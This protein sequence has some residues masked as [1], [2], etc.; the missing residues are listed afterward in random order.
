LGETELGGIIANAGITT[1][2]NLKTKQGFE[3][4]F[5]V[6]VLSHQL[7]LREIADNLRENSRIVILSSGVHEPDHKLAR[8]T[9]IPVPKWLGTRELAYLNAEGER[10]DFEGRRRYSTSK[11]GNV[12]QARGLQG[13]LNRKGKSIDVFAVDP[14]LMV[15]TE[16]ARELP[17]LLKLIFQGV[18]RL[19]TPFIDNMRLSDVSAAHLL[20]LIQDEKWQG[21]GFNYLDGNTI[22]PP[23]PDAQRDDLVEEFWS[24]SE[25]ILS[26]A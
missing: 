3:M 10:S 19:L 15:D 23:S 14:G 12:L 16:L 21:L 13:W 5:G 22:K 4:T 24:E 2:Q 20:S 7:L 11:L 18:G 26:A 9:G 17:G 6:N 8:R 25:K 1:E